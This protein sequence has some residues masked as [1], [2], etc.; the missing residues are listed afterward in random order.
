M[1]KKMRGLNLRGLSQRFIFRVGGLTAIACN[2][3]LD[4]RKS[5]ILDRVTPH[6]RFWMYACSDRMPR[7]ALPLVVCSKI[8]F[9]V[10]YAYYLNINPHFL[11]SPHIL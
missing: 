11:E 1:L 5:A 4:L 10:R 8:G 6:T 3:S 9:W 2:V 7:G